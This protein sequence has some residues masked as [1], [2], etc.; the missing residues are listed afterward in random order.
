MLTEPQPLSRSFFTGYV[1]LQLAAFA[2]FGQAWTSAEDFGLDGFIDGYGVGLR[3]LIPFVDAVCLD[4]AW[5]Q[6]GEGLTFHF[7][8]YPK[9]VMQRQRVR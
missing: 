8:I 2:A 5:G 4:V 9:A 7:G 1:G 3:V 6:P